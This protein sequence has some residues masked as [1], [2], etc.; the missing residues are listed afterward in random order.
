[1]AFSRQN[2][3]EG[4]RLLERMSLLVSLKAV[5]LLLAISVSVWLA[6]GC[7][8]GCSNTAMAA[9]A[10]VAPAAA[11]SGESCH[12]ARSHDCCSKQKQAT[13][14]LNRAETALALNAIPRG[15]MKDCPLVVN[16]TA[17]PTKKS[18]NAPDPGRTTAAALPRVESTGELVKNQFVASFLPNRGPTYLRCCVF[19]I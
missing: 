19:L 18:S 16:A 1:M 17:V 14:K 4:G 13:A 11:A 5:R 7:L 15:S 8:F 12:A 10:V 9:H 3:F 2:M 6:G